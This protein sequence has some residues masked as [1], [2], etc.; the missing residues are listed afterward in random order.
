MFFVALKS[1]EKT[2]DFSQNAL[3]KWGERCISSSPGNS[4]MFKISDVKLCP[5]RYSLN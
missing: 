1:E 4:A 3:I 5:N 2:F